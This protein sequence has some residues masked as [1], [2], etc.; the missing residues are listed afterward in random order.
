MRYDYTSAYLYIALF[1][2]LALIATLV[3][4]AKFEHTPTGAQA[5]PTQE[6][7]TP[8]RPMQGPASRPAGGACALCPHAP[9]M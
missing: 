6:A 5:R 4:A 8:P 2:I 3:Y 1:A 9:G 7:T